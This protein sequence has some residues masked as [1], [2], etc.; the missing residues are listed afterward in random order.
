ML[1]FMFVGGSVFLAAPTAALASAWSPGE[2][3]TD[4]GGSTTMLGHPQV[5]GFML[6]HSG[7][8]GSRTAS[9]SYS[10]PKVTIPGGLRV[11][12]AGIKGLVSTLTPLPQPHFLEINACV[13]S[14]DRKRW[15]P[16]RLFFNIHLT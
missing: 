8:F 10:H 11:L 5:S 15:R 7:L 2:L 4:A 13:A 14:R 16:Q 12:I 9:C 6:K 3:E 1:V